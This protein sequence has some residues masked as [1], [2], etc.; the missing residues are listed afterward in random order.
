VSL[1]PDMLKVCSPVIGGKFLPSSYTYTSFTTHYTS[2][3]EERIMFMFMR[4]S[5]DD[6]YC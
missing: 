3:I 6:N 2:L 1:Y 5:F 4:G